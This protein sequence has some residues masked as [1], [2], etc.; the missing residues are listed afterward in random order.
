M[1]VTPP[2]TFTPYSQQASRTLLD[3]VE[4]AVHTGRTD[5][6][7]AHTGAARHQ[8]LP[9][10]SPRLDFL[11]AAAD[12]MTAEGDAARAAYEHATRHP[13]AADH[14]FELA[15]VR[16]AQGMWLR[17]AR[18]RAAA[19]TVLSQAADAFEGLGAT[20]WARR[21]R[22]ELRATGAPGGSTA[23]GHTA[24][25]TQ[26]RRIAELAAGG[27]SNREIGAQLFLSPRTV[28]AHL[29]RVFPKLGITS[30]AALRDALTGAT[31]PDPDS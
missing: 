17:R 16:L 11:T 7:R 28:G 22:D 12:A 21:A 6:A 3:L 9:A 5:Q 19:R 30:R 20:P 31:E 14:P 15:R 10:I 25:T 26:E 13:A 4:A 1:A 23:P 2:G 27:L 29:Y 24:L 18:E 8:G